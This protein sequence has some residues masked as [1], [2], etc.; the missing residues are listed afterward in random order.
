MKIFKILGLLLTVFVVLGIG[1][2]DAYDYPYSNQYSG[3]GGYYQPMDYSN[4]WGYDNYNKNY[5]SNLGLGYGYNANYF[6]EFSDYG[7]NSNSNLGQIYGNYQTGNFLQSADVGMNDGYNFKKG[8][9][10]KKVIHYDADGKENDFTLT[11]TVWDNIEGDFY[12]NNV[13]NNNVDNNLGFGYGN[14]A[15]NTYQGNQFDKGGFNKNSFSQT[16]NLDAGYN[17]YDSQSTSF[18]KGSKVIFY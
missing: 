18:G 4:F 1:S 12:K 7:S 3:Y 14:A 11:E 9:Y 17:Q 8:P 6:D 13:Y 16:A 10:V 2:V 5:G 15:Y